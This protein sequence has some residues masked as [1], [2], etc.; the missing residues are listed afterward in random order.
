MI[1]YQ[2]ILYIILI[3]TLYLVI[4]KSKKN[5]EKFENKSKSK[6][7]IFYHVC[8][9]GNW[10][11]IVEEQLNLIKSSGLY[12]KVESINIGFLGDKKS[13]LTFCKDKVKLVYHSDNKKEYEI[14]TINE[15]LNFSK[16]KSEEYYILYIHTK[17]V[18]NRSQ[19]KN[20]IPNGQYYWRQFMNYWNITRHNIC[21]E[22]L[23]L[24][25]Y[26]VGV[27]CF[28]NHYSGNFWWAN[29]KYIKKLSKLKPK[30]DGGIQAEFWLLS[31]K[32][33]KK[34]ICLTQKAYHSNRPKLTGLYRLK[35]LP[36]NYGPLKIRIL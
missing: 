6:I 36:K 10:K 1:I 24:G 5:I 2:I 14:G 29:S 21:I 16:K 7:V 23:N 13:I 34:S 8:E 12:S 35:L 31:K 15:I 19:K 4:R 25:Y 28:G 11:E 30:K 17:G 26:T 27:N 20:N 22:Q 9:L 32:Q 18:T 3:L 33:N